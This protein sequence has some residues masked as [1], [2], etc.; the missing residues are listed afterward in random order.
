MTAYATIGTLGWSVF[1][2]QP[3][4]EALATLYDSIQ[5]TIILLVL[6]ILLAVAAS[7]LLVRRMVTPIQALQAGA[8]RIGAGELDQRIDVRTGDELEALGDQFN[9]MGRAA[10]GV[11][12]RSRAQGRRAHTRADRSAGAANGDRRD[13]ARDL[14][15]PTDL[16]PVMDAVVL[17]TPPASVRERR[18]F[19]RRLEGDTLRLVG[20]VRPIPSPA[21]PTSIPLDRTYRR[22]APFRNPHDPRRGRRPAAGPISG[23]GAPT[24]RSSGS[25]HC[26]RACDRSHPHSP[27]RGAPVH[28]Q[29]RSSCSRPLPD[30]GGHLHRERPLC[31][32][33]C[34][35]ANRDITEAT[36]AARPLPPRSCES[37][38]ASPTDV[39]PVLKRGGQSAARLCEVGR[40][41][42]STSS[43]AKHLRM[44][45]HIAPAIG[46]VGAFNVRP[47]GARFAGRLLDHPA[48]GSMCPDLMSAEVEFPPKAPPWRGGMA[49][50]PRW[51]CRCSGK[52]RG[53][54]SSCSAE[55]TSGR[56][57]TSRS[58]SCTKLRRPGG[59]RH[60]ERAPSS[61]A[62]NPHA[63]AGLDR[64][65]SSSLA[66]SASRQLPRSISKPSW[67]RS[68]RVPRAVE[69]R[70]RA[71]YEYDEAD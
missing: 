58:R 38:R 51:P 31:S 36:G 32:P 60:R 10:E 63:R 43:T 26:A 50:A 69:H 17:R 22:G 28:R 37:S 33:S 65:A 62:G 54:A 47:G 18:L 27:R 35:S 3:L 20:P 42:P 39:Q 34:R 67:P 49:T 71:I 30:Q 59:D 6:G 2:E 7:L 61:R 25:A 52:G 56:S 5:R 21:P 13:P 29:A 57:A 70:R 14:E 16:Q 46:P 24:E 64:W 1:V 8:V 68:L 12:R 44:V 9:Q 66:R 23:A 40:C 55:P 19:I 45:A 41:R 15:P 48:A 11:V 53:P 4:D